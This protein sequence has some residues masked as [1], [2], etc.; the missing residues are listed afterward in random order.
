MKEE[1]LAS[2]FIHLCGR[3]C[4]QQAAAK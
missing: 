4:A 3:F 1:G 2:L